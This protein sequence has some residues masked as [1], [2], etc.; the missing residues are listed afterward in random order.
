M[1]PSWAV[2][3]QQ[4]RMIRLKGIEAEL[5]LVTLTLSLIRRSAGWSLPR[6]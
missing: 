4:A 3:T 5:V 6:L 2:G 1:H